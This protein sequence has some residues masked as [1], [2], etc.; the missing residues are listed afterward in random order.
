MVE[1]VQQGLVLVGTF[2]SRVVPLCAA[3]RRVVLWR[4]ALWHAVVWCAVLSRVVPWLVSGGQPGVCRGAGC[5][6]EC[7]WLVAGG[8]GYVWVA[9]WVRAVGA[10]ACC[11]GWSVRYASVGLPS[12]GACALVPCPLAVPVPSPGCCGRALVLFRC[13]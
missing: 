7:G 2:F 8:C 6:P 9:R 5:G 1:G 3:S 10:W 11:S 4:V 12:P 13:L